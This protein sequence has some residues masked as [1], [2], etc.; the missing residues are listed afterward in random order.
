MWLCIAQSTS[1]GGG[2]RAVPYACQA[3]YTTGWRQ[4]VMVDAVGDGTEL[5]AVQICRAV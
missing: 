3:G 4:S 2:G 5:D 1:A